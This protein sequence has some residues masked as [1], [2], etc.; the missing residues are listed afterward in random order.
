MKYISKINDLYKKTRLKC[1][2]TGN[3]A[4]SPFAHT[5]ILKFQ[6]AYILLKFIGGSSLCVNSFHVFYKANISE[7]KSFSNR[8]NM[9]LDRTI[10]TSRK[11]I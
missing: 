2:S 4:M 5:Y 8:R 11:D 1:I 6:G 9:W 7:N 10:N 3:D